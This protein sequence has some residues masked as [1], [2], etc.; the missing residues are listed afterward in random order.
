MATELRTNQRLQAAKHSH[1]RARA[2]KTMKRIVSHLALILGSVFFFA[3]LV[4]MVSTSL[5]AQRQ[6]AKFPP[7]LIPNPIIWLNY[8]DV[9]Y[10]APMHRYALNTLHIVLF[11]IL[12]AVVTS[13]LAAY[14]F[15]RLKAPGK[16][17]IFM[18]L[19][20]T[21]M[22]PGVVRLIPTYI[23]FARL[24]W[25]GSFKPLTIPPLFGSAFY[26]FMMRQ[27]FMGIPMDLED[28]A[29]ID[30]CNRLQIYGRVILPLAKP[31]LATVTVL[32]FMAGWNDYMGPLIYLGNRR[33]YTLS[34]G[35]QV[36]TRAHGSE[37]G[38]LMAASTMM[39]TP[40]ILLFFFAQ[41]SF[42]QGITMTGLKG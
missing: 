20:A 15:A 37:W 22:L 40:I 25:V 32:A 13:S 42:V 21:M 41:K 24:G 16:D 36:F 10:Y 33:D 19:L 3:P 30:G 6:I 39:V 26:I 14:A 4:F 35:L 7:D 9:F 12:G 27:F 11:W 29:L 18:V 8:S 38:M 5:K 17:A 31:V 2:I 28:A 34:L 23:L 1:Q